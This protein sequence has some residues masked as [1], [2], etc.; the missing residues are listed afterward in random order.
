M[1]EHLPVFCKLFQGAQGMFWAHILPFLF[2]LTTFIIVTI[3]IL[4]VIYKHQKEMNQNVVVPIQQVSTIENSVQQRARIRN[5]IVQF[6]NWI[7]ESQSL[8]TAKM[9]L[10]VNVPTLLMLL[11]MLPIN[12]VICYIYFSGKTCQEHP[13]FINVIEAC[14]VL[15][16]ITYLFYIGLAEKKLQKLS[17]TE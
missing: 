16:P 9:M 2:T 4:Y 13:T 10:S 15:V 14:A 1:D 8:D 12:V 7:Q 3:Y 6:N 17:Q 11:M 5:Q